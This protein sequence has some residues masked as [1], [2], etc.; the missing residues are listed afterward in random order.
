MLSQGK[1]NSMPKAK[2]TCCWGFHPQ[3]PKRGGEYCQGLRPRHPHEGE[4]YGGFTP[5]PRQRGNAPLNPV[6]GRYGALPQTPQAFCK[7]L[8]QKLLVGKNVKDDVPNTPRKLD[9]KLLVGKNVRGDAPDTPLRE[10]VR[11]FTPK[12]PPTFCKKL[13]QKLLM[14]V[15]QK[16][17]L[18]SF[19]LIETM[20]ALGLLTVLILQVATVQ[21]Q[22]LYFSDYGQNMTKGMWLARRM[23]A[24]V[25]YFWYNKELKELE[26]VSVK[27]K[28][29]EDEP[30]FSYNLEIREW[31]LP[32]MNMLTGG[33]GDNDQPDPTTE[34]IKEQVAQI[35]GDHLLKI[36]HVEV[37]WG[38]GAVKESTTLTLLLTNQKKNRHHR[39]YPRSRPTSKSHTQKEKKATPTRQR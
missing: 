1:K 37:F 9:Q 34:M 7:K 13:D 17:A 2:D 33:G 21:G 36:A 16:P 20:V 5:K 4:E 19:T 12:T 38:E 28:P 23:M 8:D 15:E 14:G 11:G 6:R 27:E 39:R 35:F 26:G 29:F 18:K 31:K 22:A 32:L 25:E 10:E 3:T 30:G 24:Q